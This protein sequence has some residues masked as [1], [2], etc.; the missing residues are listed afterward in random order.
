MLVV[1]NHILVGL[2]LGGWGGGQIRPPPGISED[3][4]HYVQGFFTHVSGKTFWVR[5]NGIGYETKGKGVEV[6][7]LS[8]NNHGETKTK[9]LPVTLRFEY[10]YI[11]SL[12]VN[13]EKKVY[14]KILPRFGEML[15]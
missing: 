4:A 11:C 3:K 15:F 2:N 7:W 10:I 13:V 5:F 8:Y 9:K 6:K 1:L 12:N 14:G